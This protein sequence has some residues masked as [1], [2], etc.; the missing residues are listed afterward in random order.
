MK[1][2]KSDTTDGASLSIELT[3]ELARRLKAESAQNGEGTAEYARRVL[4]EHLRSTSTRKDA[5]AQRERN[6]R[7]IALLQRWSE[8]DAANPD[9]D[10]VPIIPPLSLREVALD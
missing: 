8:E 3:P 1:K 7:A 5:A 10:P 9:P 2:S 4:E 6:Q